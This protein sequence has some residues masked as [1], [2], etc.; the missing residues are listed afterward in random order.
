MKGKKKEEKRSAPGALRPVLV[1]TIQEICAQTG[2][3]PK[4]GHKDNQRAG[5][6]A[7]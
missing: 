7:Q 3:G 6:P 1:P 2:V 5:E 4:E